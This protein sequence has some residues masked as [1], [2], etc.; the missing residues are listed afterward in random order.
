MQRWR[1]LVPWLALVVLL[2]AR[3][4][5]IFER[6]YD[7]DEFE[8]LHAAYSVAHGQVPYRDFFEHHGPLTYWVSAPLVLW[9]DDPPTVLTGL[10]FV[11]LAASLL[12][13]AGTGL[14]AARIY[15]PSVAPWAILLTW[16]L[17][18]FVEKSVEWRPDAL[19]L[20]ALAWGACFLVSRQKLIGPFAAGLL[21]AVAGLATQKV[22]FLVIGLVIA[23]IVQ[24]R[25]RRESCFLPA[26]AG[27]AGASLPVLLVLGVLATQ[28][29]LTDAYECMILLPITWPAVGGANPIL[30]RTSWAPLHYFL[31]AT[32]EFLALLSCLRRSA[33]AR[34]VPMVLVPTL[35]H[36]VGSVV[37]PTTYLQYYVLAVPLVAVAAAGEWSRRIAVR[38][39]QARSLDSG[40]WWV[41]VAM[42][43]F[44]PIGIA[45]FVLLFGGTLSPEQFRNPYYAADAFAILLLGGTAI[46][47]L[48][49]PR[50]GRS[51]AVVLL[52]AFALP[53]V[54]RVLIPNV[55][56]SNRPQIA[57]LRRVQQMVPVGE[58]IVD[59]FT[60]L[61]ALRPHADYWWWI[62]EHTIPMMRAEGDDQRLTMLV[63]EG[64]PALI[65]Y[66]HYLRDLGS[67]DPF[68]DRH[69]RPVLTGTQRPY[70]FLLRRDL[71]EPAATR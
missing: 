23:A 27:M 64:K 17:P 49:L 33:R 61:G 20:A 44:L 43:I 22:A 46:L 21:L 53:S 9:S 55:Y 66:D 70:L 2:V 51:R 31:F 34:G 28:E 26:I 47:G 5:L 39:R 6:V 56:W 62:N 71:P 50:L 8:H 41:L 24:R 36:G 69:Y 54:S 29:A 1:T 42:A 48:L 14:L 59:G 45:G 52:L 15:G 10:R 16:T 3:V 18:I 65:L 58:T 30:S 12:T 11:S 38:Q 32:G 60:G 68:L 67:L 40:R 7:P 4:H 19:A 35:L 13:A 37:S 63:V 25:A 57:E